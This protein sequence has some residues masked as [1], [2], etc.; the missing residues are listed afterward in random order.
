MTIWR[1]HI[2]RWITKATNAYSEYVILNAFPLQQ[3]LHKRAPVLHYTY[4][5]CIVVSSVVI[6][7]L[8]LRNVFCMY[9]WTGLSPLS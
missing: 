8:T 3:W 4:I 6:V 9:R 5:A 1:V 2:A 7:H